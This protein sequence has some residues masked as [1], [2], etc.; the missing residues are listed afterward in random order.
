MKRWFAAAFALLA[1]V[2]CAG[3][4]FG[5]DKVIK[6]S[7][8]TST[9]ASGLLD[10]LLPE[11]QK[12]TGIEVK[13]I[14]KGTGAAIRDGMDG[15]VDVIF[16]HAK[17]REEQF[18]EEGYGTK[19]YAVMHNDFVILGPEKDPAGIKGMT[20]ASAAFKKIA[21]AGSIFVSRGDDSGT[22][23]KEQSL[24]KASGVEMDEVSKTIT[25]KGKAQEISFVQPKGDWYMS[26]GQGMGKAII[27]AD[28]KQAYLL[29]DRGTTIK[30]TVGSDQPI[31]LKV[32]SEG[33]PALFNPYGVIPVNPEKYPG[34]KHDLAKQFAEWLVSEKG[35]SLIA[36]Y[37]LHGQQLFYPDA[38]PDAK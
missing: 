19:R 21:E 16:V 13:V 5:E 20:D 37:K 38:I 23:T 29:S 35:Q 4:A 17:D 32:L 9:Q 2:I 36:G 28:E 6:M 11:L 10:I 34:V 1:V 3:G 26:I 24:W 7:T 31:S 30:Y 22:H 25:K 15:N 8:T 14:A 27:F 33:D 18:V 12:D